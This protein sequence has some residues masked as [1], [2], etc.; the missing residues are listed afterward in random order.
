M[1]AIEENAIELKKFVA[2]YPFTQKASQFVVTNNYSIGDV[3]QKVIYNTARMQARQ[4]VLSSITGDVQ[5]KPETVDISYRDDSENKLLSYPIARMLVALMQD[6]YLI[7]RFAL[8]ESKQ[9]YEI[10]KNEDSKTLAEVGKDFGMNVKVVEKECIIHFT[11]YLKYA[12]ALRD[13]NWKLINQ[14]MVSGMVTISKESFARLLQEAIRIRIES[15]LTIKVPPNLVPF[16]EPLLP[17][18]REA[19]NALKNQKGLAGDG[20]V[21]HDSF[22]PCM[23][24]LLGDLQKGINL[25]HTAR[26]ALTSFL[27]NI[28]LDKDAIMD[29]YR[30]APDFREDLTHYQVQHI[31]GGSGTEYTCPGCKTMMTYGNCIGKNKFCEYVTHPL[32]YYRKSQR[33]R[34]KDMVAAQAFKGSKDKAVDTAAENVQVETG[35]SPGN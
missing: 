19:L 6:Q 18:I 3:V 29:L 4:R 22:P 30:L 12:A 14:K 34:A 2:S 1:A 35:N 33:R 24:N 11:D 20:E 27:A 26:F 16:L 10:L 28:G 32:S 17:D 31:T 25:P 7:K 21:T 15:G 5:K 23:K 13:L 8:S 9:A